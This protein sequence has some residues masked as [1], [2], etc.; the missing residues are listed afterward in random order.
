MPDYIPK[1]DTEFSAYLET[2]TTALEADEVA[3]GIIGA[4]SLALRGA[5]TLFQNNLSESN[6]AK[7]EAQVAVAAKDAARSDLEQLVRPLVAR[8]QVN[9]VVTDAL[10]SAASIPIRDTIRTVTAPIPPSALVA[11]ASA[12]G[13]N[14]L[15]WNPNGNTSG[16]Q[17]VVEARVGAAA[18]FALVDV[19]TAASYRHTGQTPGVTVVY[20]VRARRGAA[21]SAPSN[22][23]TVYAS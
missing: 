2:L 21:T 6:T 19:V 11:V 15:N 7:A 1:P 13:V 16:I 9:P 3:Y 22:Q 17:F 12:D 20:Q 5:L 10:R 18:A 4:D 23:A 14:S 8:I